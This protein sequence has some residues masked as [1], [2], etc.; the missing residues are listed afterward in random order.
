MDTIVNK[1]WIIFEVGIGDIP[2]FQYTEGVYGPQYAN[3]RYYFTI[4]NK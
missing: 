2:S 4:R 1:H 3:G